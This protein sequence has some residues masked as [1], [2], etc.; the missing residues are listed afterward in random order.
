[1][2]SIKD[3]NLNPVSFLAGENGDYEIHLSDNSKNY[4]FYGGKIIFN[5][6]D[7]LGEIF[8]NLMTILNERTLVKELNDNVQLDYI[9]LRFGKKVFYKLKSS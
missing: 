7:N 9:D 1:M 8:D 6:N 5:N 4:G 3:A 2:K